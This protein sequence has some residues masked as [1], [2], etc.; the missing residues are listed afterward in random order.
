MQDERN[1]NPTLNRT[2]ERALRAEAGPPHCSP[3]PLS[4]TIDGAMR[5]TGIGRSKLYALIGEGKLAR[6]KVGTRTLIPAAS[7][8]ALIGE[9]E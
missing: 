6:V 8:R 3:P 2:I 5:A 7:L 9:A 1:F 4:Y